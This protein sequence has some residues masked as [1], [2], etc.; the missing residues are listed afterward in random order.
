MAERERA[1][2]LDVGR[3]DREGHGSVDVDVERDAG[4]AAE[5][6]PEAGGDA[7]PLVGPERRVVMRMLPGRLEAIDEADTVVL[8]PV[9]RSR[10]LLGGILQA[11]LDRI[12]AAR[13]CHFG[14]T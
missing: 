10:A 11:Q 13:D 2:R 12:D 4:L 5:I 6:E 1:D 9:G 3:A 7:A 14:K 8:R